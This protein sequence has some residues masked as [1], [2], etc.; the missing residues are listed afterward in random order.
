[1][2]PPPLADLRESLARLFGHADFRPGQA[3]IVEAVAAGR[4]ALVVHPTGAGKS[5]CYQLPAAVAP[6]ERGVAL[7]VSPLI[8]LMQDQVDA[9]GKR[10]IPAAFLN[11]VLSAEEQAEVLARVR[12]REVRLLYVAPERLRSEPFLAALRAAGCW[13]VACDEAH[14]ISQ[15]GHDFRPDY[16]RIGE[17]LAALAPR[18]AVCALTATATE[19]VRGEIVEILGLRDPVL[20]LHGIYRPNLRLVVRRDVRP[21]E[22]FDEI[23]RTLRWA[24]G[25]S[26]I[27]YAGTRRRTDELAA[28]LSRAGFR[29]VAYHAGLGGAERAVRQEGFVSGRTPVVV[30]TNAFGMGIDK[31]DIRAVV[32]WR[33]PESLEAY[34]QEVGRAGRDGKPSLCLGYLGPGDVAQVQFLLRSNNPFPSRLEQEYREMRLRAGEGGVVEDEPEG[35]SRSEALES[36]VV[37]NLL[38]KFGAME[39]L[40]YGAWRL[41][42]S[43]KGLGQEERRW[44]DRKRQGDYARLA[45]VSAYAEGTLCRMADLE[46]Y[47]GFRDRPEREGGCGHCDVCAPVRVPQVPAPAETRRR[48]AKKRKWAEPLLAPGHAP[49]APAP[50]PPPGVEERLLEELRAWRRRRAAGHPAYTILPDRTL[51]DL[52]R[53]RPRTEADLAGI[54]GIGP[55]RLKLFGEELL[56]IVAESDPPPSPP[57]RPGW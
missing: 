12:R 54:H 20:S 17:F 32:H 24:E 45:R 10:G 43:W 51:A 36:G 22:R 2:P 46:D 21:S 18:P 25:G 15:W 14:C 29:T 26:A 31:A 55:V 39:R 6:P 42:P 30:A 9:L 8:A 53:S 11:S 35:R 28:D 48:R 27:V 34:Y 38:S 4:D 50:P 7:V 5:V 57:A 47:F 40:P 1:M 23:A 19:R 3:D 33:L 52:V 44:L 41:E 56:S 37:R 49:P 16:A 13:L